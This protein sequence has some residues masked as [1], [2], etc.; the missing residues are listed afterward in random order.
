M[1]ADAGCNVDI[2][3]IAGDVDESWLDPWDFLGIDMN[4]PGSLT[5]FK[6]IGGF[7]VRFSMSG[8]S[9]STVM[10]KGVGENLT[11]AAFAV[12]ASRNPFPLQA[13]AN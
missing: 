4:D 10:M 7:T 5:K 3:F 8:A 12:A 11:D 2:G 13:R 1:Q 9:A 6:N